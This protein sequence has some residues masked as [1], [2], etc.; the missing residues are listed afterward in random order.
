MPS[1]R[2]TRRSTS[3]SRSPESPAPRRNTGRN[4]RGRST[5][6]GILLSGARESADRAQSDFRQAIAILEPLSTAN[7]QAAQEL[8]RAYNNLGSLLS[9]DPARAADVEALWEKAIAID[10]RLLAIDPENREYKFEL[11]TYASNLAALLSERGD[12]AAAE[13]RSALAVRLME[14][15]SEVAPSIAVARADAHSLRGIILAALQCRGG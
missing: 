8:A 1:R 11:A 14:E 15:L 7:A 9:A 12:S 2:T 10:L 13:Q 4:W 6:A 3:S 5:T